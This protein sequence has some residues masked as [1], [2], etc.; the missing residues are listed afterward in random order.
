MFTEEDC[1]T[2]DTRYKMNPPL[3]SAEDREA[4]L[5]GLADGLVDAIA[6]DHAPH[7]LY[8]KEVE[9]DRAANGIT[10]LEVCLAATIT[11]LHRARKVP[12]ERVV[13]LLSTNPARIVKLEG[14]GT[15][16]VG[17]HADVVLFNPRKKWIYDVRKTLS[18]SRNAPYDGME[19]YGKTVA[20]IVG[21]KVVY[22]G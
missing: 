22:E 2:Y 12:L 16:A 18:K 21:G 5:V 20:T 19:F 15:L 4:L 3:R 17:A 7:A 13:E 6:T 9:F 14:R 11:H 1:A 10:G 8:E